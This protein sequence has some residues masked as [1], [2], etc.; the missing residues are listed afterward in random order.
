[1]PKNRNIVK[2]KASSAA[3]K[4]DDGH[5]TKN[6]SLGDI[7]TNE[8]FLVRTTST[9]I[10]PLAE[11]MKQNG[12]LAPILVRLTKNGKHE[13]LFGHR[14]YEAAKSIKAK[15]ILATVR[16]DLDNDDDALK[17]TVIENIQR[18]DLTHL[19]KA[20]LCLRLQKEGKSIR[21]IAKLVFPKQG[22][23]T[24]ERTVQY[25]LS[26][27][28]SHPLIIEALGKKR[29][30]FTIARHLAECVKN[31]KSELK[32]TSEK[33]A[34][35]IEEIAKKQLSVPECMKLI[36]Q[37]TS[38]QET[39]GRKKKKRRKSDPA[40]FIEGKNKNWSLRVNFDEN[41][42]DNDINMAVRIKEKLETALKSV[43]DFLKERTPIMLA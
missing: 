3:K 38:S 27:A 34:D 16:E 10:K 8:K 32:F 28:K 43:N 26:V 25:Y 40:V 35:I 37:M 21:D 9:P 39:D 22:G 1:M 19:D 42:C 11:N 18:E 6:I 5:V 24:A 29:I 36:E 15:T 30:N 2:K 4:N 13:I 12:Q 17:L 14:R 31:G 20:N 7:V 23:Q 33:L 41:K